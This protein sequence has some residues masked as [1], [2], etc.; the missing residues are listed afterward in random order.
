MQAFCTGNCSA[1]DWVMNPSRCRCP[2]VQW[3]IGVAKTQGGL[4]STF[5]P[6]AG[7]TGV[8][9]AG[10]SKYVNP[11]SEDDWCNYNAWSKNDPK[12]KP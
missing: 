7:M 12:L 3:I 6:I 11:R 4:A 1:P 2:G 5:I 10:L 9:A 8:I